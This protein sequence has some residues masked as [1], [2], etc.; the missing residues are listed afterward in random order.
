MHLFI[1]EADHLGLVL[2]LRD[3]LL[4]GHLIGFHGGGVRDGGQRTVGWGGGSRRSGANGFVRALVRGGEQ[5]Y[6]VR[7]IS[8]RSSKGSFSAVRAT[9]GGRSRNGGS[10]DGVRN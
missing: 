6:V 8:A 5:N 10:V 9:A 4:H 3:T 7:L 1:L 2:Y